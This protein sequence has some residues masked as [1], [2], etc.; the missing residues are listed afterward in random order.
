M[1]V[2][3]RQ[4]YTSGDVAHEQS[5]QANRTQF[6]PGKATSAAMDQ[7]W[8]VEFK[9]P[10]GNPNFEASGGDAALV[11]RRRVVLL[12]R[13]TVSDQTITAPSVTH[14]QAASEQGSGHSGTSSFDATT[15]QEN[16]GR[17]EREAG[18]DYLDE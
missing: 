3:D 18:N 10:T 12:G 15:T 4:V 7:N 6:T 11:K 16:D 5:A 9:I 13:N 17:H 2:N 14:V 8:P 1:A